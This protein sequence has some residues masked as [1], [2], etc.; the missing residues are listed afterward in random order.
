MNKAMAKWGVLE[1]KIANQV[2]TALKEESPFL[3]LTM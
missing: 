3:I 1:L 2:I